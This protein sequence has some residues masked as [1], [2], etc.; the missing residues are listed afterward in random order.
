[1]SLPPTG[2]PAGGDEGDGPVAALVKRA[3][4][5]VESLCVRLAALALALMV[6]LMTADAFARYLL[7]APIKGAMEINNEFLMPALV[8][9]GISYVYRLGGHVRVNILSDRL[10]PAVQRALMIVFDTATALLFAALA[11]GMCARTLESFSMR[12]YSSSPLGYL[13]A[14]SF[15]IVVVGAVLMT[16]RASVA[17]L[18]GRH[19]S[20]AHPGDLESY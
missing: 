3:C 12:E 8:F 13:L 5:A 11:W 16:L 18:T 4:A 19:P 20:I 10:P 1:M 17:A 9:F 7:N 2:G 15:A 6:V 14:P